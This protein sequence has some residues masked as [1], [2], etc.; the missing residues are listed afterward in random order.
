MPPGGTTAAAGLSRIGAQFDVL[1]D[2]SVSIEQRSPRLHHESPLVERYR[3]DDLGNGAPATPGRRGIGNDRDCH[4]I[5]SGIVLASLPDI[6]GRRAARIHRLAG[7]P[8][9]ATEADIYFAVH[10][11]PIRRPDCDHLLWKGAMP[12]FRPVKRT[13]GKTEVWISPT[14]RG[15]A[16]RLCSARRRAGDTR[17]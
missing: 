14:N 9:S 4:E 2:I 8:R 5:L 6:P 10:A 13:A 15:E 3:R 12:M 17:R 11:A 16:V 1:V 7:A